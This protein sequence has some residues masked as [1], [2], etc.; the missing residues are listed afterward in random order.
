MKEI[1]NL[2]WLIAFAFLGVFAMAQSPTGTVQGLVTD[3]TGAVVQGATITIVQ[4][5]TNS[6]HKTTSDSGGR[7]VIP[8]VEP[9][10]Y[11]VAVEATGFRPEKQANIQVEV[12]STRP[13][14]FKLEV[15]N[16]TDTITVSAT[17]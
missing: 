13:V 10:I 3:K 8:F 1:R 2:L 4:T 7:Y 15:G 12:A 16:T 9:G 17:T 14:D 5:S 6:T 11:T